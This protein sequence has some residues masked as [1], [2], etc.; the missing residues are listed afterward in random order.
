MWI[1]SNDFLLKFGT[2]LRQCL[3]MLLTRKTLPHSNFKF[4]AKRPCLE[5]VRN[6]LLLPHP[7]RYRVDEM[8]MLVSV[9]KNKNPSHS[10]MSEQYR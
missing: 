2:R 4:S 10:P 7:Y 3:I 1:I 6:V 9:R 8:L 5:I